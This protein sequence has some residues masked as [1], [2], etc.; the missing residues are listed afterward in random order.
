MKI[1]IPTRGRVGQQKT[2]QELPDFLRRQTFVFAPKEE[3][4]RLRERFPDVED[5][6]VTPARIDGIA[7]KRDFIV[8][9]MRN[10]GTE[11]IVM[12][13]DDMFFQSRCD[14]K[15]REYVDGQWKPTSSYNI[16]AKSNITPAR[17][18][19]GFADL[20]KLLDKYPHGGFGSRLM[21]NFQEEERI[22]GGR[23]MHSIALNLSALAG[24]KWK[25]ADVRFR[26]D[27]HVTITLMKAGHMN[28]VM[29][30]FVVS[31]YAYDAPGGCSDERTVESSNAEAV[32]LAALHPG[33]VKVVDREYKGVPR[34][35][36]IVSWRK[37]REHC[38]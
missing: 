37:L 30:D 4:P 19:K 14:M 22:F 36:V 12:L 1:A 33:Y 9:T 2:L 3:I 8:Q 27:F 32:K 31:P 16:L 21:N 11:K 20:A 35:E 7:K 38:K 17:V 23:A 6:V 13:D 15:H 10:A 18:K 34:K 29:N 5:F 25:F 26:E 24:V 28:V